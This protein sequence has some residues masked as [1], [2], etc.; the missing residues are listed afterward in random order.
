MLYAKI[1]GHRSIEVDPDTS[2]PKLDGTDVPLD[3]VRL[4]EDRFHIIKNGKSFQ[5]EIVEINRQT[6]SVVVRINGSVH[7]VQLKEKVDLLLEKLGMNNS[8]GA[9]LNNLRAPMPGL[10]IDLRVSE[11]QTIKTGDP[12]LI[13]EAMK[14]EN[15]I[16]STGDGV[17]KRVNIKKGDSVEKGHVL[18]E[19]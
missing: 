3:I 11:G 14:M 4:S 12:L 6:K 10:I 19:F 16:K 7:T 18:I 1:N 13:L 8:G 2:P 5:A 9:R 17:V 15:I